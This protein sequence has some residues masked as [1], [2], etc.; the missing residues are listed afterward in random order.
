M[1]RPCKQK[2]IGCEPIAKT[3]LPTSAARKKLLKPIELTIEE[4]EAIR[5]KDYLGCEQKQAADIMET[6]QPTFHRK[7][8][9]ARKKIA[10]ALI[11]GRT[12]KIIT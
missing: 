7:Y 1:A 3:F 5:L 4:F 2:K 6:S 11:E 9:L 10:K 8:T 12:I